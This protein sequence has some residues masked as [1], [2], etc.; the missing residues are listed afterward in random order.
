ML[1]TQSCL[2]LA[3][4]WIVTVARQAPLSIG[5]SRQEHWNRLSFPFPGDLPDP[6]IKPRFPTFQAESLPSEPPGKPKTSN[7]PKG[8][9][10]ELIGKAS[11]CKQSLTQRPSVLKSL[12]ISFPTWYV[13]KLHC[14]LQ[15]KNNGSRESISLSMN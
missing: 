10:F 12:F 2:I 15:L 7:K 5:F 14:L 9:Q 8:L 13:W 11:G 1:V 6:G 3:T 4:P